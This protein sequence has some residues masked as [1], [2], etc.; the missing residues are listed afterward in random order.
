MSDD[1]V[2]SG[3]EGLAGGLIPAGVRGARTDEQGRIAVDLEC[4]GCQYNLRMCDADGR[5]P[6]CGLAV[7][8][9]AVGRYLCYHEPKWVQ[10][11]AWGMNRFAVAL[12]VMVVWVGMGLFVEFFIDHEDAPAF[13]ELIL[14][15]FAAA[16]PCVAVSFVVVGLAR[17]T[18]P[19]PTR[20]SRE[21]MLS[22]RRL[23]RVMASLCFLTVVLAIIS[24]PT[25]AGDFG[26]ILE[27]DLMWRVAGVFSIVLLCAFLAYAYQ[28]AGMIPRRWLA[29]WT[30]MV[31]ALIGIVGFILLFLSYNWLNWYDV[32]VGWYEK[33]W[34]TYT[35][36]GIYANMGWG[37]SPG[38]P[39]YF[40]DE[41]QYF[42][43]RVQGWL[44]WGLAASVLGIVPLFFVYWH[45]LHKEAKKAKA[46]WAASPWVGKGDV[47]DEGHAG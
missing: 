46:T 27:P 8:R 23:V 34:P 31:M 7:G 16:L 17:A 21:K 38:D 4:I 20:I 24:I 43:N 47:V 6:E 18:W 35:G 10:C 36:S 33:I 14:L 37:W 13:V 15:F 40:H 45:A 12:L 30:L 32:A 28:L 41:F 39:Y 42:I 1:S 3:G 11:L 22:R 19:N 44:A 26:G 25:H 5:C 29:R 9:S 2:F